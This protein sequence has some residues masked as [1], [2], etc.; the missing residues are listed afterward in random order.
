MT[1]KPAFAAFEEALK[2]GPYDEY[3]M[4]P[5]G[6]DP[7]ICLSRNDRQQPFFLICEYDTVL[8]NMSGEGRVEYPDGPVRYHPVVPGDFVYIPSGTPHRFLPDLECIQLR[9]KAEHPGLE[10]ITWYC[11]G[12]GDEIA[13]DVWDTAIELPQAGYLRGCRNFNANSDRR[14]CSNCGYVHSKIDLE[15]Y[16]WETIALEIAEDVGN[17]A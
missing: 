1:R 2:R 14:T 12:C 15:P 3:P 5:A 8:V 7:Q 17:K 9:Y 13:R 16:S 4:L 6:V 11:D 10:A